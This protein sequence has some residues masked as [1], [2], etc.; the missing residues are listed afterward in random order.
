MKSA[1]ALIMVHAKRQILRRSFWRST[2]GFADLD[3]CDS[4]ADG[5][6]KGCDPKESQA[7]ALGEGM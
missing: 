6:C 2:K 3:A 1:L 5:R 4:Q 7:H